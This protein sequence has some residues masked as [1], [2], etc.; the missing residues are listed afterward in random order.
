MKNMRRFRQSLDIKA[1]ESILVYG[2]TGVLS[3]LTPE[4]YPY[5]VPVNYVYEDGV[6]YIHGA[7]QGLKIESIRHEDKVSFCV[8]ALDQVEPETFSTR[9]QSVIAFGK[10]RILE[11]QEEIDHALWIFSRK[12]NPAVTP[13]QVSYEMR[14]SPGLAI[15]A[16]DV[17][18]LSGKQ[19]S[20]FLR[21]QAARIS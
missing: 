21:E 2:I 6:I 13:E 14:T 1:C 15:I 17:E 5:G 12:Y 16:I 20:H 4:G 9:Y 8:I 11:S 10:A 18:Y 7:S 3:V 19:S